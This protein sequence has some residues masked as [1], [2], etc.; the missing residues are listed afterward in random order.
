[1]QKYLI[2]VNGEEIQQIPQTWSYS[3]LNK[4]TPYDVKKPNFKSN[5]FAMSLERDN[6]YVHMRG[7]RLCHKVLRNIA[8]VA[9]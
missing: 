9:E 8:M 3:K 5:K 6:M 2:D 1:M 4:H 7:M